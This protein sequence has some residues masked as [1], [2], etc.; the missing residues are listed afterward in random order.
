MHSV[1]CISLNSIMH[2]GTAETGSATYLGSLQEAYW[3][4]YILTNI[5]ND[6]NMEMPKCPKITIFKRFRNIG[7]SATPQQLFH[8]SNTSEEF[9]KKRK[10]Y[11]K[12]MIAELRRVGVYPCRDYKELLELMEV[13]LGVCYRLQ[14]PATWSCSQSKM[15]GQAALFL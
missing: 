12:D 8:T 14:V 9:L 4:D 2:S 7:F 10:H 5:W 3:R 6:L 11:I 15:D 1:Y 13:Y